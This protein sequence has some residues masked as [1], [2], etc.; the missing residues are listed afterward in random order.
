MRMIDLS[1]CAS[2]KVW[3]ESGKYQSATKI[4][5]RS[6]LPTKKKYRAKGTSNRR[7]SCEQPKSLGMMLR[8]RFTLGIARSL[9]LLARQ[10][11]QPRVECFADVGAAVRRHGLAPPV[12]VCGQNRPGA[13][14]LAERFGPSRS[15]MD[16]G[17][18]RF[19]DETRD[20]HRR[21][22]ANGVCAFRLTRQMNMDGLHVENRGA[23]LSMPLRLQLGG[24]TVVCLR[25][26]SEIGE[27]RVSSADFVAGHDHYAI[28]FTC[29]CFEMN[30]VNAVSE[31]Q[32][33]PIWS[34]H[35]LLCSFPFR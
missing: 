22:C 20:F 9:A 1:T 6:R 33:A 10:A 35:W 12:C 30:A 25:K 23:A 8:S 26:S 27:C 32:L 11:N 24:E 13:V 29:E 16:E 5:A 2:R 17:Q 4:I 19:E 18:D 14:S 15:I 7:V 21:S 28:S 31:H 34:A 3:G